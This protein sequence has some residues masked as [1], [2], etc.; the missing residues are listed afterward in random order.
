MTPALVEITAAVTEAQAV[1]E[2]VAKRLGTVAP[3]TDEQQFQLH[4][5]LNLA[6]SRLDGV[7]DAVFHA[8]PVA[9]V[10]EPGALQ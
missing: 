8:E 1:V 5:A 6:V 10:A 4:A 3:L 7:H 9:V 2:L